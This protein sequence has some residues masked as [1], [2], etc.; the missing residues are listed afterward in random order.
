MRSRLLILGAA[1]AVVMAAF[2]ADYN[3]ATQASTPIVLS[4]TMNDY[5]IEVRLDHVRGVAVLEM[6]NA[7]PHS[8]N[9]IELQTLLVPSGTFSLVY[10]P[11]YT[12]SDGYTRIEVPLSASM[13]DADFRLT[14]FAI[15]A[16]GNV[17]QSHFW[18]LKRRHHNQ[19]SDVNSIYPFVKKELTE[20]SIASVESLNSI[21]A[22]ALR[23]YYTGESHLYVSDT[24]LGTGPAAFNSSGSLYSAAPSL[25]MRLSAGPA[26]VFTAN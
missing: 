24:A 18:T 23:Y 13:A 16:I 1:I 3:E 4:Q 11:V 20:E 9:F 5:R 25:G 22:A 7:P 21:T 15:D 6:R 10:L 2:L 19:L 12:N 8:R 17:H 14:A 26:G